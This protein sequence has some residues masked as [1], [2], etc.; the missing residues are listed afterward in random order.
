MTQKKVAKRYSDIIFQPFLSVLT[1]LCSLADTVK[2]GKSLQFFK[3][4]K[5]QCLSFCWSH[6]NFPTDFS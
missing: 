4:L 3:F 2:S 1:I 6:D 5:C